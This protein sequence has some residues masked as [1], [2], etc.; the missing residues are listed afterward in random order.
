MFA[1]D[2][3]SL[4]Q[5]YTSP[6]GEEV[7]L[8]IE[9]ELRVLWPELGG[10]TLLGLGYTTPYMENYKDMG[11]TVLTC[12]PAAQ[13]AIYWPPGK[14]NTVFLAHESEIPLPEN[15]INRV[16]LIHTVE[17]SEQLAGMMQEIWRVLTPGGRVLAVVPNRL[18]FWSL[19]SKSPFGYGRPFRLTQLR[20]LLT[21]H[22][23]TCTR[24]SSA[25]FVPPVRWRL[26]WRGANRMEKI[27]RLLCR[28]IGG[29]LII[30][31]EKQ[32]Y[33]AIR[34]PVVEARKAYRI[35]VAATK[36]AV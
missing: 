35:P 32:L 20:E 6:F 17:N 27:G 7:R 36:P 28:L 29:V 23:F 12:M 21:D 5:F 11:G 18:G 15:S 34:Q 30:E 19:S 1:P 25:L 22:Q 24:S 13:G 33:A 14:A 8:L 26:I 2:V 4:R 31:A 10:D 3:I 9:R 16:L